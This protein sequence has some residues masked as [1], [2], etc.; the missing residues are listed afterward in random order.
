MTDDD[1]DEL[2]AATQAA[3]DFI[4]RTA[5]SIIAQAHDQG[6]P[7]SL[8]SGTV[9]VTAAKG[10]ALAIGPARCAAYLATLAGVVEQA[11][12]AGAYDA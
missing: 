6:V 1:D 10:L 9:V 8:A 2:D 5:A 4:S 3:L 11:G 7:A 12:W